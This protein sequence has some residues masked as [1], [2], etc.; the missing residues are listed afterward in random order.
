MRVSPG[1]SLCGEQKVK[2]ET[3]MEHENAAQ[4]F[5]R[6]K[7]SL[8]AIA[9]ASGLIFV[10]CA[11]FCVTVIGS[12]PISDLLSLPMIAGILFALLA[13]NTRLQIQMDEAGEASGAAGNKQY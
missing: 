6:T 10:I 5:E 4:Q 9:V 7:R 2:G 3:L 1:A 11:T 8:T 13:L 12:H